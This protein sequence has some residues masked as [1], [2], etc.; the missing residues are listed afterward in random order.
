MSQEFLAALLT[1]FGLTGVPCGILLRALIK[2]YTDQI[3]DLQDRLNRALNISE[4]QNE[5]VKD[6]VRKTRPGR[7]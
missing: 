6:V 7:T 4:G 5:V 2:S 1:V 3:A